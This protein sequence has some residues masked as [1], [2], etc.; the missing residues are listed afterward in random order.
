[1]D[2]TAV[3]IPSIQLPDV[4]VLVAGLTHSVIVSP[5]GEVTDLPNGHIRPALGE[6]L[7]LLCHTPATCRRAGLEWFPTY[8]ILEL[9]AFVR[10]ARF[11]VPTPRGLCAAT[12][13]GKP[14]K[15]EDQA[16]GLIR[17]VTLLLKELAALPEA[18]QRRLAAVA[19]PMA[20]ANWCWGP[21]VLAA[22]S[23]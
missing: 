5:D 22:L 19:R 10:P 20:Q 12:G 14:E 23:V 7:P 4:P 3:Q 9:Y 17:A 11:C 13:Q 16:I 1:M 21:P 6:A 8:D 2:D 18:E 15:P